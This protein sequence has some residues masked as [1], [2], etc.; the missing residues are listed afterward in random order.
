[1]PRSFLRRPHRSVRQGKSASQRGVSIIELL[2]AMA[3]DL[4]LLVGIATFMV[5]QNKLRNELEKSGRQIENGRYA[6][7]LL[8]QDINHAGYFG[9]WEPPVAQPASLPDPCSTMPSTAD[10]SLV[11]PVQAFDAPATKPS[12]LPDYVAGT[13]VLV[14]RRASTSALDT[15]P[16]LNEVYLQASSNSES[17][18]FDP[19]VG[20]VNADIQYGNPDTFAFG[21]LNS[22]NTISHV[23]TKADGTPASVLK[24]QNVAGASPLVTTPRIAADI[25]KYH[26][27]IYFISPCSEATGSAADSAGL[28]HACLSS[29][30]QGAPVPTLK[31]LVLTAVNGITQFREEPLVEGI[32]NMQFDF[33]VDHD[34]DGSPD[35]TSNASPNDYVTAP[36]AGDW[37]NIMAVRVNL[38]SRNSEKTLNSCPASNPPAYC[39]NVYN[40]GLAGDVGPFAD[41]FKRHAYS[42]LMMLVNP[43]KRRQQ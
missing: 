41:G 11:M 37:S 39:T 33:G 31:R 8:Q 17:D 42:Q 13:D 16:V 18:P 23:G 4:F 12:C 27:H 24:K 29:D 38:L 28:N 7:F 15:A 36:G 35:S 14:I 1:M 43:V 34:G 3:I 21:S 10:L 9:A 5:H 2:I 26:V 30:D 22:N 19:A 40:L 20:I 6:M 25:W 32:E